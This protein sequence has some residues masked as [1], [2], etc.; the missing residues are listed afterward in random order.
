[1]AAILN[2]LNSVRDF[3]NALGVLPASPNAIS[4]L[5]GICRP[6]L[7][8]LE[9]HGAATTDRLVHKL[10][11]SHRVPMCKDAQALWYVRSDI[12]SI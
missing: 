12:C 7:G 9:A 10:R 1:M 11:I 6:I 3:L 4:T 5:E 2:W 8:A